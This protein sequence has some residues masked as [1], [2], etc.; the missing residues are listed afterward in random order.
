MNHGW[1]FEGSA[2]MVLDG[3]HDRPVGPSNRGFGFMNSQELPLNHQQTS[4]PR[5]SAI[6]TL[7]SRNFSLFVGVGLDFGQIRERDGVRG[8]SCGASAP[9][10]NAFSTNGH[11][12]AQ[13]T[14]RHRGG[15]LQ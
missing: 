9:P 11:A 5:Q 2:A 10:T 7:N 15:P 13:Q 3:Q 4:F 14:N 6:A 12:I 8:H 1:L